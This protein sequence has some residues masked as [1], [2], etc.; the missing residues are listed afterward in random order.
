M[1]R[2]LAPGKVRDR[3]LADLCRDYERR[4]APMAALEIVA[5]KDAGPD[6]EAQEMTARL[7]SAQ[8]NALVFAMDERGEELSSEDFARV[9]GEHGGIAFLIGGADGLGAQ[10]RSRADRT[11]RLSRMTLPHELARVVLLEQIYRGLSIL[12]GKPYHRG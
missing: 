2:I 1:I 3:R 8:G 11:L 10:A 4:I 9:L 6:R 5:I 7:G 12:K